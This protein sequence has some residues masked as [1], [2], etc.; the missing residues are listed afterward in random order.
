MG[1]ILSPRLLTDMA[2]LESPMEQ[3]LAALE[4]A[5]G[6]YRV[7]CT[8]LAVDPMLTQ[9]LYRALERQRLADRINHK[10]SE[11]SRV[12]PWFQ[13]FHL[14]ACGSCVGILGFALISSW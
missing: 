6:A 4:R 11:F 9:P 10:L 3:F 2:D 1:F 8:T 12:H 5:N 7:L 14:P 13:L